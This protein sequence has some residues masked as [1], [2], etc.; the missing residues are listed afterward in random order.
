MRQKFNSLAPPQ[1]LI[2][3]IERSREFGAHRVAA[4]A[5]VGRAFCRGAIPTGRGLRWASAFEHFKTSN[6][7]LQ[8]CREFPLQ[9]CHIF[10]LSAAR[11]GIQVGCNSVAASGVAQSLGGGGQRDAARVMQ[12]CGVAL[13]WRALTARG[14]GGGGAC[15]G[16]RRLKALSTSVCVFATSAAGAGDSCAQAA[17]AQ[18]RL[19][20]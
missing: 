11:C 18:R 14:V 17:R 5:L 7:S 12:Q 3:R 19:A 15:S 8:G 9:H 6:N 16:R 10:C 2:R 4:L 13:L 20:N 1:P